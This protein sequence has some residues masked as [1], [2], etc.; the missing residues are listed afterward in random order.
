M[1]RGRMIVYVVEWSGV[2]LPMS[3]RTALSC[4]TA[5]PLLMLGCPRRPDAI[6]TFDRHPS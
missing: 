1:S 5:G 4:T 3:V 2:K 6:G